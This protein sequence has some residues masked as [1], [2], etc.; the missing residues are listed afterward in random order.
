MQWPINII[1]FLC[2]QG[3][4]KVYSG[5]LV[6]RTTAI[7]SPQMYF[8]IISFRARLIPNTQWTVV[9]KGVISSISKQTMLIREVVLPIIGPSVCLS[10]CQTA[11]D[12]CFPL[13]GETSL[14]CLPMLGTCQQVCDGW[15]VCKPILVFSLAKAE[16]T[17]VCS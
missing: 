7:F 17:V 10:V 16:K 13:Y 6:K 11:Q 8:Q 5:G 2:T 9:S 3:L 12:I 4:I 15:E 1:L 14:Q